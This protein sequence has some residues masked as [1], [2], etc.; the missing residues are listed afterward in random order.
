M[1]VISE[2]R[3]LIRAFLCSDWK[4]KVKI[5]VVYP[6]SMQESIANDNRL[7]LSVLG[8]TALL[9]CVWTAYRDYSQRRHGRVLDSGEKSHM[10]T[11]GEV[12]SGVIGLI[13]QYNNSL[14]PWQR[15]TA[16]AHK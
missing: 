2:P 3:T 5:V 14:N 16:F 7:V 13:G 10:T 15:S 8:S 9:Y 1:V 12:A 6:S 11:G 4:F